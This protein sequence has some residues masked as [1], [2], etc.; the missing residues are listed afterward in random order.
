VKAADRSCTDADR[1]SD[2]RADAS[3]VLRRS[4][5]VRS[6]LAHDDDRLLMRAVNSN[7]LGAL[8]F[9]ELLMMPNGDNDEARVP[10]VVP[11]R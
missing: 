7:G 2:V 9:R 4:S 10:T 6:C 8:A 11:I 3:G 5:A 1:S